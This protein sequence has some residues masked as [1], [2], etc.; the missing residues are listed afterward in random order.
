MGSPGGID[1]H[2]LKPISVAQV[3]SLFAVLLSFKLPPAGKS[4]AGHL[5]CPVASGGVFSLASRSK[6]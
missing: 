2:L 6:V 3:S 4:K 1:R 5:H